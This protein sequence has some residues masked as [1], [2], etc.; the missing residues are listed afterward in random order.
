[1]RA[2]CFDAVLPRRRSG[3]GPW[4][5]PPIDE[6]DPVPNFDVWQRKQYCSWWHPAQARMFRCAKKPWKF[7]LDGLIQP[8]ADIGCG[9]FGVPVV[10]SAF[11]VESV[12]RIVPRRTVYGFDTSTTVETPERT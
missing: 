11:S 12:V 7:L 10:L 4:G 6:D 9:P 5:L 3:L 2:F 8:S 1:M